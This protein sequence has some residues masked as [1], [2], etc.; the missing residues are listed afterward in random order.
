MELAKRADADVSPVD[1]GPVPISGMGAAA[2][3]RLYRD[4]LKRG[5]DVVFVLVTLPVTLPTI[6]ILALLV[7][8]DG[9]NPFFVQKRV[10]R[11]GRT[12]RLF[13]LRTMVP[14]AERLLADHLDRDP[15]A[16][17]EWAE[18]QKLVNDPRVTRIGRLLR[19]V[20]MDELPQLLNVLAGDMALVGPRPMLTSQRD[21]YP[22]RD[23]Y[24]LRPGLT[25]PWQISERHGSEFVTRAIYDAHYAR[26]VSLW[27]DLT[28]LSRTV[29]VVARATGC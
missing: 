18:R 25:G 29:V 28:V 10:G 11:G 12:F 20:S 5:L 14:D 22:G 23:Y 17:R 26:T 13:K 27:T 19:Q 7:S 1:T 6:L 16:A 15:E 9:H 2:G 8:L 4:V 21:L 3:F 24:S